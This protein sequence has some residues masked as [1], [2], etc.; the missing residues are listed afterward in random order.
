MQGKSREEAEIN[1]PESPGLLCQI[2]FSPVT[3]NKFGF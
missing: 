2:A 1:K 3:V